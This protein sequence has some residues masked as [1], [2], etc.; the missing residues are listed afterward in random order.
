MRGWLRPKSNVAVDRRLVEDAGDQRLLW[1]AV[2]IWAGF[3]LLETLI[4]PMS[5]VMAS[6]WA[7]HGFILMMILKAGLDRAPARGGARVATFFL[8]TVAT[9]VVQ[10]TLDLTTTVILGSALL[11]QLADPPPGTTVSPVGL[12]LGLTF[13][14]SLRS[15]LWIYGLY[16][17]AVA[18]RAAS[19]NEFRAREDSY[20]ARLQAQ[21]AE[22]DALRLQVNPHFLF[23]ALNG[24]ASLAGSGQGRETE[25]MALGLARYYRTSFVDIDR[26]VIPLGDELEAVQAYLELESHRLEKMSFVLDCPEDL[27]ATPVPAMILQ[28]LVENA[29]KY[30]A[31]G[32]PEPEPIRVTVRR[33]NGAVRLDCENGMSPTPDP[34]GTGSG[35]RTI[36]RRLEQGYGDQATL[37]L[38]QDDEIWRATL[39]FPLEGQS[40]E[41]G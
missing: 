4:D 29:V 6:I 36:R 25:R 10:T 20:A 13:K 14:V 26:D 37:E 33:Q 18:L 39:I 27:L 19:R 9:A 22:L 21:R 35:L 38:V 31:A 7:I 2:A 11:A 1:L 3:V 30:G 24:L 41:K 5:F 12:A 17:A 8:L 23:N 28:P 34:P 32:H 16:A 15:Y 40:R